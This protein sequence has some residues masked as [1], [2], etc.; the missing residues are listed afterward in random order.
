MHI[1]NTEFE[2]LSQRERLSD[3]ISYGFNLNEEAI[4]AKR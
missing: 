1:E 2:R 4:M 3:H